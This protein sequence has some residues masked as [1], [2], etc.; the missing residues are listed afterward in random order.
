MKAAIVTGPNQTPAYGDFREPAAQARQEL[1]TVTASAL[2]R[3]ARS[4][5]AGSHY[6]SSG[7]YPLVV[8]IDGVGHTQSGRRVYFFRPEAPF[9]AMAEKAPV[10]SENCIPVPDEVGDVIAAAIA[11]PALS[12]VAALRARAA[13]RAGE[14]VLVNGATGT[15]GRLAVQIAKYM[16]AKKIIATGRDPEALQKAGSLGADVTINLTLEQKD[17]EGAL[18]EQFRDGVDIVLDYLY[19][20]S[21]ETLLTTAARTSRSS[22]PIR[23]VAIGG[24]AG[25]EITLPSAVLRSV[26]VA[27]MGSGI[28]SVPWKDLIDAAS[29]VMQAVVPAGLQIQTAVVPLADVGK[30]WNEDTGRSRVVFAVR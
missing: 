3:A 8:G 6:S 10:P 28:G 16:G 13:F 20:K 9:G 15:A 26:P 23:Y 22:R 14:T 30:T 5:A 29:Y 7:V 12:S 19:G 11:N 1:I 2:S 17:L 18:G 24:L 4:T 25:T 27:I 21:T